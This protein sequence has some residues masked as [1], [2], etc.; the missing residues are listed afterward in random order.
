[1]I[2]VIS[3]ER[4]MEIIAKHYAWIEEVGMRYRVPPA[5]VK[6]VLFKEMTQTDLLDPLADLAVWTGLTSRMDSSTGYGQ[7][8]GRTGILAVNYALDQGLADYARL[9]IEA[10]HRL[11]GE[12]TEDIR[13]VWKKLSSDER[14]NIEICALNLRLCAQEMTGRTDFSSFSDEEYRLTLTRYNAD[15]KYV[16]DY[17]EDAF[18][19]MRMFSEPSQSL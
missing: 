17:G 2:R 1:M 11:S 9:G 18:R 13:L 16:T 15:V 19:L 4:A 6:A 7:I 8:F 3:Q 12:N 14:F 10:D 5:A